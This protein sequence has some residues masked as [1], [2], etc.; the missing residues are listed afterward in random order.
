LTNLKRLTRS[1]ATNDAFPRLSPDGT[2]VAFT[3]WDAALDNQSAEI[4]VM[5]VDGTGRTRLTTNGF[6]DSYPAWSPDGTQLVYQSNRDGNFE[7]YTMNVDGTG[8]TRLTRTPTDETHPS[9]R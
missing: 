6:E 7:I 2:K 9:W 1:A 3:S 4:D 8:V 5:N